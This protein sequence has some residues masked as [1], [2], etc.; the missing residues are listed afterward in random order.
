MCT[1][2]RAVVVAA[3]IDP[4]CEHVRVH[5]VGRAEVALGS[6]R[7]SRAEFRGQPGLM[8]FFRCGRLSCKHRMFT[9]LD[10]QAGRDVP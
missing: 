10:D 5:P 7:A 8:H 4:L 9:A 3:E 2:R 1:K 6:D